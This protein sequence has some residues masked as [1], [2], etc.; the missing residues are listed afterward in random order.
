MTQQPPEPGGLPFGPATMSTSYGAALAAQMAASGVTGVSGSV[1]SEGEPL[2][3]IRTEKYHPSTAVDPITG[4]PRPFKSKPAKRPVTMSI[5]KAMREFDKMSKEE[6][7]RLAIRLAQAGLMLGDQPNQGESLQDY[8]KH[9]TLS[10]LTDSYANLL[11]EAAARYEAGHQVSPDDIIDNN[12]EYAKSV[13]SPLVVGPGSGEEEEEH[14]LANK[15][16]TTRTRTVDVYSPRD[17]RGLAK[18][19]LT[20]ELGREPTEEEYADFVSALQEEQRDNPNI[21]VTRTKH[22]EDGMPV[23]YRTKSRGGLGEAGLRDF[24]EEYAEKQPGWAE[25]QAI[26]TY[27]PAIMGSLGPTVPGA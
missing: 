17:A 21:S 4:A 26:G 8:I 13:G 3:F 18:A 6:K 16:T 19:V 11:E 12:I 14:P 15:T 9:V 1:N 7:R 25:W 27:L 24:A 10:Q 20:E 22:D 2:I 23:G 5:T